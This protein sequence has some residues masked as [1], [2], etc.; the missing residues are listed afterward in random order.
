MNR[1]L[2]YVLVGIAILTGT[3]FFFDLYYIPR[4][5][6]QQVE[7]YVD[8]VSRYMLAQMSAEEKVGQVLHISVPGKTA[9]R[10]TQKLIERVKPGGVILFGYNIG[11]S[12]ELASFNA[13]IQ[14]QAEKENLVPL[15]ISTDQEGGRVKRIGEPV[16]EMP[17]AMAIGQAGDSDLAFSAGFVT[18]EGLSS[19]GVNLLF[20][21]VLDINNNPANPVIGQRSFGSDPKTVIRTAIPFEQGAR[22][23]GVLPVIKHFPGHG[24]TS[25]DSHLGLPVID[26]SREEL[27]SFELLPFA[28]A[29]QEGARAVMTAHIVFSQ[30]DEY[31]ATLSKVLLTDVLRNEFEFDGLVFTDAMEMHAISKSYASERPAVRALMSGADVILLTSYG[32]DMLAIHHD[33]MLAAH[34]GEFERDGVNVLDRAV[35]RQLKAKVE[36]GLFHPPKGEEWT[37][38]NQSFASFLREKERVRAEKMA[39]IREEYKN[40]PEAI[41][42]AAVRSLPG[43]EYYPLVNDL[44][45]TSAH[46][47]SPAIR[48]SFLEKF[49]E[50]LDMLP[51]RDLK[52]LK[53][54]KEFVLLDTYS[55]RDL[56]AVAALAEELEGKTV[57]VL[58]YGE[59]LLV[60][61]QK[62]NLK[63]FI[64]SSSVAASK[65]AFA[66]LFFTRKVGEQAAKINVALPGTTRE[67]VEAKEINGP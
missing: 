3:V 22:E 37:K 29:I 66:E 38:R 27:D 58:H 56:N 41:G 49:G 40:V 11:T 44:P 43:N 31:P 32:E 63:I 59:P 8:D 62:E 13:G 12:T 18:A 19:V 20:A 34:H 30:V 10:T 39:Y 14:S 2:I 33:L 50:K 45:R 6:M 21:P 47:L 28:K 60:Y 42:V 26:K 25:V 4:L 53:K 16:P 24:D 35:L 1:M 48:D 51:S 54:S 64:S 52:V 55:Q 61:P 23:G 7:K 5:R 17:S 67:A 9:N 57:I 15:F 36:L 65:R 46:L